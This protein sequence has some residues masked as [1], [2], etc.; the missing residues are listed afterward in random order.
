MQTDHRAFV[1]FEGDRMIGLVTID[2]VRKVEAEDRTHT[3]IRS[4]MTPSEKLIV[5]AP[6]E[7][8]SDALQRLQSEEIRQLPVVTGDKII[9]LLRRKDIVRWL[10][11]Q[12]HFG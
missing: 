11:L 5:I 12:S 1:V 9:G 2:D 8:A 10:E 3:I 4:S 6:E 7:E